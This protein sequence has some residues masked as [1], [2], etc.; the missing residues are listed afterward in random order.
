[1][2]T[3]PE[4]SKKALQ[5]TLNA[6]TLT[7]DRPLS[8][9]GRAPEI[10]QHTDRSGVQYTPLLWTKQLRKSINSCNKKYEENHLTDFHK[11]EDYP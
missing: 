1:M 8:Q 3:R 6:S 7:G 11:Q 2:H 4:T 10:I 9:A 5:R